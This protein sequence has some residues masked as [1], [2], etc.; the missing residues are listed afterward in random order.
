MITMMTILLCL[1]QDLIPDFASALTRVEIQSTI[2]AVTLF[3]FL[4]ARL[5]LDSRGHGMHAAQRTPGETY[6]VGESAAD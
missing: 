3:A 6:R 2:F 1:A 5:W 4:F